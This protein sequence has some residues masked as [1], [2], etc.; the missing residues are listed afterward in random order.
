MRRRAL[1]VRRVITMNK[2]QNRTDRKTYHRL[3][4]AFCCFVLAG[5]VIVGRLALYQIRDHSYY[6]DRVLDQITVSANV[7]PERGDILDT[8]GNPLATNKTVYNVIISPSDINEAQKDIDK[9]NSDD[10]TD[11]DVFYNWTSPDGRSSY[12]G[13]SQKDLI[14]SYLSYQ[15]GVDYSFVAEKASKTNR[16]YEVIKKD[17]EEDVNEKIR[18]F[19]DE[20]GL[21]NQIYDRASSKRY[22]PYGDLACHVIGFTNSDGVGIYG[23]EKYYNNLLEGVSGK[24]ILAQDARKNDMPFEYEAYVETENG[25]NLEVTLDRYIQMELENQLEATW[26]DSAAG[27]RV[28][29]IV[30]NVETGGI[31]AMATYP[32]YDLNEPFVLD[33]KSLDTLS[34]YTEGTDEYNEKRLEL[35][36]AMWSNKAIT[37][38]YEPGS[39]FKVIT[40]AGAL[41]EKVVTFDTPFT[42]YGSLTI[43]NYPRPISCHYTAG[44]GTLPFRYGLQQSCN[45]TLM[46]VAALLGEDKFYDY[47][48]AFGYTGKTGIDLPAEVG[49]IY[50]PRSEFNNVSLAVYSFGQTF[51]T[52]PIQQ[53][54]AIS[55]VANGG[56]YIRPHL[57]KALLDDDGNV[58]ENFETDVRRQV[59]S[60]EVCREI[61]DVLEDGVSGDGGAKN[62]YVKGY[63]VAAKT[64]TSEKRDKVDENGEKSFRVGS[65]VGFAPSDDP[66][67]AAIIIVDEPMKGPVYGSTVA[68]PYISKLFASILPYLGVEKQYT[69]KDLA[70]M[71]VTIVNYVGSDPS[72]ARSDL[73]NKGI[74]F[75]IIGSGDVITA[76]VPA[77]GSVMMNENGKVILYC[78]ESEPTPGVEVPDVVGKSAEVANSMIVGSGLNIMISG[79]SSG[80]TAVVVNQSPAAGTLAL[81]GQVVEIEL[82]YLDG[83]D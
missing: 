30:M 50:S 78:G 47:F 56:Y 1:F 69:E 83:T 55:T 3:V 60:T 44:H 9:K 76:Q 23:L 28:T 26:N 51:K 72:V 34:E 41:E 48:E 4:I 70:N 52:T 12:V 6:Q 65:T 54:T 82:R 45:P 24:Y 42:C 49:G 14:C 66:K 29:G 71:E 74:G 21:T 73:I 63:K 17:V 32:S 5:A 77:E 2:V 40:T 46:Q 58:I 80:S 35:L 27:N 37:E 79:S 18:K 25:G 43:P 57:F 16:M 36:Y 19:I 62:A 64:G 68:A 7:N 81:P 10:R 38:T 33:A 20:Y 15:L 75:E 8:N 53:L 22:Y 31:L 13:T 39:T 67:V 61:A 11:N 59:V